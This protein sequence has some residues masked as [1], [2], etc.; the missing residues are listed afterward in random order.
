MKKVLIIGATGM[1]GHIVY[2]YLKS[3]NNYELY[4]TVYRNKLTDDSIICDVHNKDDLNKVIETIKP[5]IVIN[6][7]GALVKQSKE[8]PEDAIY[9]N[10]LYPHLLKIICDKNE[11]KLI[12]I[13]TD[14][15][16]SGK[17]GNYAEDDFRDAD[18]VYGRSKAMGEIFDEPHCTIRTSII[19]PELKT[20][21]TGL[22]HWFMNQHED[23]KGYTQ[24]FWGGVTTLELAKVI[25]KVIENNYCGLIQVSNGNKISKFSL[26]SLF[27]DYFKSNKVII[28]PTDYYIVD[29]SLQIG[30]ID[31][32]I[33]DYER[34]IFEMKLFMELNSEYY[35]H[36]FK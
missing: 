29:K 35:I 36:Y 14:C 31:F 20:N 27:S 30:K 22:F 19:G 16:F 34:M 3:L 7:V 15:V 11:A 2:L 26:L 33:P 1:L 4:N 5:E 13:S 21:G 12:H 28:T 18:D 24:A 6:C 10:A 9:L 8:N 25:N 17:K 32:L 23:I